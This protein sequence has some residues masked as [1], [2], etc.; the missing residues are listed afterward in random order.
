M[1]FGQSEFSRLF[2][3]IW[4]LRLTSHIF[5]ADDQ[6][7]FQFSSAKLWGGK[8]GWQ[9]M[10]RYPKASHIGALTENQVRNATI[11]DWKIIQHILYFNVFMPLL[12]CIYAENA[13]PQTATFSWNSS[14]IEVIII[15]ISFRP[16]VSLMFDSC[17]L[18]AGC[19]GWLGYLAM[20]WRHEEVTVVWVSDLSVCA[21]EMINERKRCRVANKQLTVF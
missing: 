7:V 8:N 2:H 18:C 11:A 6:R 4:R 16:A 9:M 14:A 1:T 13:Q 21:T 12:R 5:T 10:R 15:P 20:F 3:L 17:C 19:S